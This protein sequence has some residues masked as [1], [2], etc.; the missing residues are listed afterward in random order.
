MSEKRDSFVFYRS[1]YD[2]LRELP[3][4]YKVKVMD[5]IC[6]YALD[7]NVSNTDPVVS[8]F[9][10]LIQ[11][12]IDANNKR[13]ENGKKGGRPSKKET[14]QEEDSSDSGKEKVKD[15]KPKSENKNQTE[16]KRNQPKTKTKPNVTN[17]EPN[18]YVYDYVDV[19]VDDIDNT[20]C[21][22]ADASALFER[23]WKQYPNKRGKGAVSNAAKRRI[24]EIGEEEMTRALQRYVNDLKQDAW[25]KPQN[26]STFF[27]SG[28]VDYLDANYEKPV[29]HQAPTKRNNFCN[30]DER[31]HS[32]DY[33]DG[34][35]ERFIQKLQ[36]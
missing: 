15:T 35:E 17:P 7:G 36:A 4:E 22:S 26:G 24:A 21:A 32:A 30:F 19:Y 13:Y 2:A 6:T 31:Q 5:A 20:L 1:F 8:A 25:R 10:C 34:L 33:F 12:Q 18:V 28:Y 23:L 16:T 14:K 9:M 11:P 29:I 3:E 27:N